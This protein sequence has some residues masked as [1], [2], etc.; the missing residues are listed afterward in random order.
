MNFLY[1]NR[2]LSP[3]GKHYYLLYTIFMQYHF[4]SLFS[5]IRKHIKGLVVIVVLV[6][7]YIFFAV[8]DFLVEEFVITKLGPVAIYIADRPLLIPVIVVSGYLLYIMHLS[9]TNPNWVDVDFIAHNPTHSFDK[10]GIGIEIINNKPYE[11]HKCQAYLRKTEILKD[12]RKDQYMFQQDKVFLPEALSWYDSGKELFEEISL[13]PKISRLVSIAIADSAK[14]LKYARFRTKDIYAIIEGHHMA[15][16]E[17]ICNVD[18]KSLSS[19][20]FR[21]YFDFRS[22]NLFILNM[23]EVADR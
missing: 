8:R 18:E 22:G 1:F 5:T 23:E 11:L 10:D 12:Y 14:S 20:V 15:E 17:F 13:K 19:K 7:V 3:Y 2:R 6:P 9:I 16:I 21:I 4:R